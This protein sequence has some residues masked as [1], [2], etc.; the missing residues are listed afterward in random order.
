MAMLKGP[1]PHIYATQVKL[2]MNRIKQV[3]SQRALDEHTDPV[4][5]AKLR[6][7]INAL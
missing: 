7:F 2:S 4:V 3:M 6:A 1:H 5:Q